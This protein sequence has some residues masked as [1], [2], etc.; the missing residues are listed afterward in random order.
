MVLGVEPAVVGA[1]QPRERPAFNHLV[2]PEGREF[3]PF[4][5]PK[6]A[7]DNEGENRKDGM[8]SVPFFR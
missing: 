8:T 1:T 5:E 2:S 6:M 3:V 7:L 4:L